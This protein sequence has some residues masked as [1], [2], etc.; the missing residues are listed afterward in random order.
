MPTSMAV[1]SASAQVRQTVRWKSL[2]TALWVILTF[3]LHETG[4]TMRASDFKNNN[5]SN[6]WDAAYIAS[7]NRNDRLNIWNGTSGDVMTITG[8]GEV[9]IGVGFRRRSAFTWAT[10]AASCSEQIRSQRRQADVP[11]RPARFQSWDRGRGGSFTYW[12]RDS[13]GLYSFCVRLQH[14]SPGIWS[15]SDG[16]RHRGLKF[17]RV[18]QRILFQRRRTVLD[19]DGVSTQTRLASVQPRWVTVLTLNRTIRLRPATSRKRKRSSAWR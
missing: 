13:T 2:G 9:G 15:N 19:S 16:A 12:N 5:G 17:L 11:T 7:N 3:L 8:D 4:T 10:V 6:Y 1:M 14:A 18:C